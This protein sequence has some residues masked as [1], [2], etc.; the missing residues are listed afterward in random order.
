ML[1]LKN[2]SLNILEATL[3][4]GSYAVNF[5][6]TAR[7]TAVIVKAL[8]EAGFHY[9]EIGH[10]VGMGGSA[11]GYGKAIETDEEYMKAAQKALKKAV[12]GMFC[13]PGIATLEDIALGSDHGM[14]FV[15]V[16]TNVNQVRSSKNFIKK[17]KRAGMLVAANYMKSY[18]L[19]PEQF[20]KNVLLSEEYGA[21]MV[22]IVDSAG[23]MFP[24]DVRAYFEA[25]RRVSKIAIGFHG[26]N[27][28]GLAIANSMQAVELG[29]A[30]VD[31]S[32]QGLGRGG[33][34]AP[35]EMLVAA[36]M[37]K[38]VRTGIDFLKVLDAGQ[39]YIQP[40]IAIK[41]T[42][43]L[44][45]VC[46]Y[47]EFHSSYMH[48]IHKYSSLYNV[49]PS[50]LIME[51]CKIDKISVDEKKLEKLARHLR[52][53]KELYLGR[54]GFNRYVGAEQDAIK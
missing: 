1:K 28:L 46:G 2:K 35:T 8:E 43:P 52:D 32:L 16:G 13:I 51:W 24:E 26:H 31:T 21:D 22:Y 19:K 27:N 33:G 20:A 23:S 12:Y 15:R 40:M 45:V 53:K 39:K 4:D 6:F 7:D 30:F 34:N 9:I 29:A 49:D 36:L 14:G 11:K 48:H 37:K 25:I 42:M 18:A 17:A 10:G 50:L 47:A 3:R 44:D 5:S 54:Y 38:G 41:G